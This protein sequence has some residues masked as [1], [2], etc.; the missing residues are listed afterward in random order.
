MKQAPWIL[1][2]LLFAVILYMQMCKSKPVDVV[3]KSAYEAMKKAVNDTAAYYEEII[4]AD[5]DAIGL[6]ATRAEES[7]QRARKSEA[8]VTESQNI[9]ARLNAKIEAAKKEQPNSTFIPVSP[10]Y[11]DGCD[12][13]QWVTIKQRILIDQHKLDDSALATAKAREIAVRDKKINDQQNFNTSLKRQLDSCQ[14]KVKEKESQVK[15]KNQWY[16]EI[17]LKGNRLHPIGGGEIRITLINKKGVL[18]GAKTELVAGEV[19]FGLNTGI[20]LF[21]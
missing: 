15:V 2:C 3:P 21:Q 18:Y 16:G 10:N 8:K 14:D 1:C 4:K 6:A 19:W 5:D 17:G 12:S 9:I 13:L 11:I 7:D 20:K